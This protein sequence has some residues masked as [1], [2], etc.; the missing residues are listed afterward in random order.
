MSFNV[1]NCG[2]EKIFTIK[3]VPHAHVAVIAEDSSNC[4][5]F[6]VMVYMSMAVLIIGSSHWQDQLAV[7][8]GA[9]TILLR[10]HCVELFLSKPVLTEQVVSPLAKP[11][12]L[13]L[14]GRTIGSPLAHIF[15]L[16][17][18][19]TIG[20]TSC[21]FFP[22]VSTRSILGQLF[23]HERFIPLAFTARAIGLVLLS[24]RGAA[25]LALGTEMSPPGFSGV[26]FLPGPVVLLEVFLLTR[27]A[28]GAEWLV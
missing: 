21:A 24:K 14:L 12:G 18:N 17:V 28:L 4:A 25:V 7:T 22:T 9:L 6:M 16:A 2:Q 11:V 10:P 27:V 1:V 23:S 8:D 26:L 5:R 15:G 19:T 13:W 20:A 3:E